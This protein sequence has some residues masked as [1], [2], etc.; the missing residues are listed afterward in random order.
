[1]KELI[2][3]IKFIWKYA[4]EEKI[5]INIT[6]MLNVLDI[7]I[8]III[9]ILSAQQIVN[10]T[11]NETIKLLLISAVI[12][13]VKIISN[14][15]RIM[16][17]RLSVSLYRDINLTI[18]TNLAENILKTQNDDIDKKGSGLFIQ[19]LT[20]DTDNLSG[21]FDNFINILA[22]FLQNV[23][24]LLAILVI[25]PIVFIY[26]SLCICISTII[27]NHRA[28]EYSKRKN[29]NL[30]TADNLSG[31]I[32]ELVRGSKDI[33]MLNTEKVFMHEF[34]KKVQKYNQEK[35]EIMINSTSYIL[36]S[37]IIENVYSFALMI[38][39][40][41]FIERELLSITFGIVLYNYYSSVK[42]LPT[43]LGGLLNYIKEFNISSSRIQEIISGKDFQKE[44]F[45]D[46][47]IDKIDG[48]FEF[49][50]VE[51]SYDTNKVLKGIDF[52]I[53]SGETVAF[54]GKS[55]AGKSTI[56]NL[57]CKLYNAQSGSI[58]IDGIDINELDKDSIRGNITIIS[59][60]PYIFNMSIKENLKIV[61]KDLTEEEMIKAC[62]KAC[63]HDFVETLPDKYDTIIGEDG[64][65]LSGGQKQRLAIARA[66]VQNTKII[67]FDEATSSLDNETQEKIQ[68]AIENMKDKYTILII[69]HRLSTIK[70]A[71]RILYLDKGKIIAEGTH[72]QLM[73]NC[74]K[75]KKLYNT[76]LLDNEEE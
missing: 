31:F 72:R 18:T 71:E 64:V 60:D 34:T 25:N 4:K 33:K 43:T 32:G 46:K 22:R 5:K 20:Y 73:R 55:G 11:S 29:K 10:L 28:N 36:F 51:F 49:N 74:P 15:I 59:Q 27:E 45:G 42:Y 12:M 61:K 70:N 66:L 26:V 63:L 57:I 1:M 16:E 39:L 7:L 68:K 24:T 48:N 44:T 19:R 23:G 62:K 30:K 54:V 17:R 75:Y 6:L 52:K 76:E 37:N 41:I 47:H 53:N 21:L 67:L 9:P 65:M 50:N 14:I 56:F 58:K 2:N 8:S 40:V 38:L 35:N 3:N 13:I 69:A